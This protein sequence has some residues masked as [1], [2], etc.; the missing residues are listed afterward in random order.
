[1]RILKIAFLNLFF[2]TFFII[3]SL[4][5]FINL[6]SLIILLLLFLSKRKIFKFLRQAIRLYGA[7][8]IRI[9]HGHRKLSI[10]VAIALEKIGMNGI[11]LIHQ[12]LDEEIKKGRG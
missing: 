1:M 12:Q 10:K 11:K 7:V 4:I 5:A 2:Y 6:G 9:L 3:F 8:I